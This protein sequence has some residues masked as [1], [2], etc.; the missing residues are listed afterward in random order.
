MCYHLFRVVLTR[1]D[2]L[3]T[4]AEKSAGDV[5]TKSSKIQSNLNL[6]RVKYG[7]VVRA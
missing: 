5:E 2:V 4:M 7:R 6:C 3:E 1:D